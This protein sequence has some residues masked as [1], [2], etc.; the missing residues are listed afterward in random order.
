MLCEIE[1]NKDQRARKSSAESERD[2]FFFFIIERFL[3]HH[4]MHFFERDQRS[5]SAEADLITFKPFE[6][7]M[8]MLM[9]ILFLEECA[10]FHS[11]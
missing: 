5:F 3:H 8:M 6:L 9:M 2:E 11:D 10:A 4:P 7:L 1:R